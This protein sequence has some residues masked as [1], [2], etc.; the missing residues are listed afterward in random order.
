[1]G[2]IPNIA[3][4][5]MSASIRAHEFLTGRSRRIEKFGLM[6][7]YTVID[8][9]CGPGRY[10][11]RAV[12]LVGETGRVYAFD[13]HPLFEKRIERIIGKNDLSNVVPLLARGGV[14][15]LPNDVADLIYAL[16]MFHM[17]AE[18]KP[19]LQEI[20]RLLKPD[21]ILII[22]DGHQPREKTLRKLGD[23]GLWNVVEENEDYLRCKPRK[24]D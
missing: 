6:P 11:K 17:V 13:I 14:S 19:F 23:S 24:K 1:M 7:G 16:D 2:R 9:G 21:G 15:P 12:Q 10:V 8:Y 20:H 4:R 18:P 3:F 22:D 5:M